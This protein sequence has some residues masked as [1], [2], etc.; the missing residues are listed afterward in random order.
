VNTYIIAP[1]LAWLTCGIIKFII[2]SLREKTFALKSI[3][4]GGMP[5][6]HTTIIATTAM[7]IGFQ[8]GFDTPVFSLA[9]TTA[10]LF[11][12][13][14]I[15]LRRTVGLH[16]SALNKLTNKKNSEL[17]RERMGHSKF[18]VLAGILLGSLLGYL[19]SLI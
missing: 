18:E 9:I 12:L 16:A 17:L 3:G 1:F 4:Y 8:E 11:I 7:L 13:D 19:L 10:F 6:N 15:S 5:S 2:N 14:A